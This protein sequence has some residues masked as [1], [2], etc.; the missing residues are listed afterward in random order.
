MHALFRSHRGFTLI[1]LLV[2]VVLTMLVCGKATGETSPAGAKLAA[3]AP[4]AVLTYDLPEDGR[5]SLLI[6]AA[7][8]TVVREL[9]HAAPRKKGPNREVWDGRDEQGKP[10]PAGTYAWR[11]L[12]TQ[13]LRAEYLFSL[14]IN[15][16]PDWE[17]WPGNHRAVTALACDAAGLCVLNDGGEGGGMA[18][19]LTWQDEKRL[20]KI[21]HWYETWRGM[22]SA[23][24]LDGQLYMLQRNQSVFRAD[25]ATGERN[26]G[27]WGEAV[28][29]DAIVAP[30][31]CAYHVTDMA[32]GAGQI[33]LSYARHDLLR[34]IDPKDGKV[35]DEAKVPEP[36]GVA[37]GADGTVYILSQDRVFTLTRANKTPREVVP[38]GR[39]TAGFRLAVSQAG[40][41]YVAENAPVRALAR[42]IYWKEQPPVFIGGQQVKRFANDGRLLATYGRPAGRRGG[43]YH[44]E[45]FNNVVD[46]EC[47]PGG[48]FIV[49]ESESAPRRTAWFGADGKLKR[50]WYGAQMYGNACHLDRAN[51]GEAWFS[52]TFTGIVHAKID[53]AKRS[54]RVH[55]TYD[56][57]ERNPWWGLPSLSGAEL[58]P[59]HRNGQTYLAATGNPASSGWPQVFLVDEP[60]G[61][62]VPMSLTDPN[63][64]ARWNGNNLMKDAVDAQAKAI[65]TARVGGKR[66]QSVVWTAPD[67]PP[68]RALEKD[69]VFSDFSSWTYGWTLDTDFTYLAEMQNTDDTR[70]IFRLRPTDWTKGG[71]P[72]YNWAA[73]EG[74]ANSPGRTAE[75]R[76][77]LSYGAAS[78]IS[79]GEGGVFGL[80]NSDGITAR[81]GQGF[82][83]ARA[84]ANRIVR[85]DK[86]G[87]LQWM[88]GRHAAGHQPQQGEAK[89]FARATGVAH[90]CIVANDMDNGMQHVWDRDGLWVGRLLD[91]PVVTPTAPLSVYRLHGGENFGG[92]LL[93]VTAAHP[94]PGCRPGDVLF[95]LATNCNPI[96]RI[97]GRDRFR[98]QNGSVTLSQ[99]AVATAAAIEQANPTAVIPRIDNFK[100]DGDL[101]EWAGREPL[102]IRDGA[103]TRAKVW[104]GWS[105]AGLFAAFDVSTDRPWKT[106]G[107]VQ[108]AFQGG[109]AVDLCLGPPGERTHPIEGDARYVAAP[110][111]GK[112]TLVEFLPVWPSWGIGGTPRPA[113]YQ[114]L[115]GKV[116]FAHVGALKSNLVTVVP[117]AD[118]HGYIVEMRLPLRPGYQLRPGQRLRLEAGC[119]IADTEGEKSVA[120]YAWH[121][122]APEEQMVFDNFVEAQLRPA[123]WGRAVLG[124]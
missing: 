74:I 87:R 119:A 79:D 82:W 123:H 22:V 15:N 39:I 43:L 78:I 67:G 35:I 7:D 80:Y 99:E 85:W 44:P 47:P 121:S 106:A 61:R 89:Y 11:L 95:V 5:V 102:L 58:V 10:V 91:E 31:A 6:T 83:G 109:A 84:G 76:Q 3:D 2:G 110:I 27:P 12:Q 33:V 66:S 81:F 55:A 50:E 24:V 36:Y 20:W 113:T 16:R 45:D 28:G 60:N 21:P 54:W 57:S 64:G 34:W 77:Q 90:G 112:A 42:S 96:Y 116:E 23:G 48:G 114:T 14:G 4:P 56:M 49:C 117:R 97:T 65:F 41:L 101:G 73:R 94:V 122:R 17:G 86:D 100:P 120:R 29:D 98:R 25:A 63:V 40:D 51:P 69:M 103:E 70:N 93:E 115:N 37:I 38:T 107:Q 18:V 118:G 124:N 52:S 105:P 108:N 19:K 32:T 30:F 62:L 104:V 59:Q 13:G 46:I 9:L 1:K 111:G 68:G 92:S 26:A 53:W 8:G 71:A 88:V 75:N 72:I